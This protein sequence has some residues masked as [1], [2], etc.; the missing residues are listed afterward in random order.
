AV[1]IQRWVSEN[2]KDKNF[3]VAFAN[4]AEVA[5]DLRGDCTEHSVLTAAMCRAVD[6][7]SR[8]AVGLIYA[9]HLGGF[10]F[11][12]WD[13]VYVNRRWVAID[14]AFN[15]YDVD[16]TH[17]KLADT[18]LDGVSPYEPFIPIVRVSNKMTLEPVEIP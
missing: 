10:G 4:A 3:G 6:V 11:H 13:E 17:I 1:A 18:S 5:R 16:A 7:P 2:I 14:A 9:D 15:Q 12:A 8:V